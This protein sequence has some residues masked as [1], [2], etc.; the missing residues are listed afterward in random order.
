MEPK[1][2]VFD[3]IPV[4]VRHRTALL[5]VDHNTA[6]RNSQFCPK[7][8]NQPKPPAYRL[9]RLTEWITL[10]KSGSFG[11]PTNVKNTFDGFPETG[12]TDDLVG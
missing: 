10:N 9:K 1:M 7:A 2:W 4:P 8:N 12:T 5:A 3:G 6:G 11:K